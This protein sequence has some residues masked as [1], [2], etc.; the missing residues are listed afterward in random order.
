MAYKYGTPSAPTGT[1]TDVSGVH[2]TDCGSGTTF[3]VDL[4]TVGANTLNNPTGTQEGQT[5]T[6]LLQQDAVTPV[7]VSFGDD[8][9][10]AGGASPTVTQTAS[11]VDILR[12]TAMKDASGNIKLYS[13][14]EA[15]VAVP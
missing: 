7:D 12:A 11:A 1:V 4:N 14:Y 9:L 6:W 10:F 3:E 5:Y 8:F 2:S 15:N 13:E